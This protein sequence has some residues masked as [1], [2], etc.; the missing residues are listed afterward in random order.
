VCDLI[1]DVIIVPILIK[2]LDPFRFKL[3]MALLEDPR[4]VLVRRLNRYVAR[5]SLED[6][7]ALTGNNER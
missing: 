6:G 5:R 3:W 1:I 2:S 7:G 4:L